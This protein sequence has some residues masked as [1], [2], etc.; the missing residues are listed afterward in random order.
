VE[1]A[2]ASTSASASESTTSS[3]ASE[4]ESASEEASAASEETG[5]SSE[6]TTT[7]VKGKK[8]LTVE[9]AS[10]ST[11]AADDANI[12]ALSDSGGS[13]SGSGLH[14]CDDVCTDDFDPVT[15]ENGVT[16]SNKCFMQMEKC[17]QRNTGKAKKIDSTEVLRQ[18]SS[19]LHDNASDASDSYTEGSN[20][21][22]EGSQDSE[23]PIQLAPTS[24]KTTHM[25][26]STKFEKP[27]K[28]LRGSFSSSGSDN[29]PFQQS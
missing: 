25:P 8:T 6:S 3:D 7:P 19:T 17:K 18:P 11:S 12:S 14:G 27:S 23:S 2:S 1:S 28:S 5:S 22:L 29:T 16:Y 13:D 20:Y 4:S 26:V 24:S 15:D 10:A 21:P 9:S